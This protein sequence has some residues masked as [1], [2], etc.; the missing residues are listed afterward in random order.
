MHRG[1]WLAA[2]V[3]LCAAAAK[4]PLVL[5]A[6]G[7]GGA[8]IGM[9]EVAAGKALGI[10]LSGRMPPDAP[11]DDVFDW[12]SCHET[13]L[14]G[15][16]GVFLM[17][18]D[19]RVTRIGL[20]EGATVRTDKGL[21]V[22]ST[23]RQVRAAYGSALKVEAHAY[24]DAPAHYLTFKDRKSGRGIKYSTDAKGIVNEIDA[25]GASIEY[26]EGCA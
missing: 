10:K 4:A 5:T 12:K 8:R 24:E 6:D 11:N 23:E 9:T 16:K 22:G 2:G 26:I 20:G 14:P 25:G 21:G 3:L 1:I 7:L 13:E 15:L 17:V 18:E 19:G